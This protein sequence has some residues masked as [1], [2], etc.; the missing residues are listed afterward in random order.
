VLAILFS[1]V[2]GQPP[3]VTL[4]LPGDL[5]SQL[6]QNIGLGAREAGL[7]AMLQRLKQHAVA[8]RAADATS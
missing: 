3:A 5:V 4:A 8:A 6:M 7:S 2:N 1:G